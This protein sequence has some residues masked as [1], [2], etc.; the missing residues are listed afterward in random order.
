MSKER[1]NFIISAI[2]AGLEINEPID[3][4]YIYKHLEEEQLGKLKP[5]ETPNIPP[6]S[7][8]KHFHN[9]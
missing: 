8:Y 6:S 5:S 7:L 2:N 1:M 3:P 9:W 4:Y